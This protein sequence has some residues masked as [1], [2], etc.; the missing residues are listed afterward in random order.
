MLG[1]VGVTEMEVR[2]AEFTVKVVSPTV[3]PE[4]ALMGAVPA[5]MAMAR[6]LLL[7]IAF[8]VSEEVQVTCVVIS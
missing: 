7:T 2:V 4:V 1:V 5:E 6:P 8:D 3:L